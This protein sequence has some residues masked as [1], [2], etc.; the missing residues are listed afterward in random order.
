MATAKG[1][2]AGRQERVSYTRQTLRVS[3]WQTPHLHELLVKLQDSLL[4][5]TSLQL[6]RLDPVPK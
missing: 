3:G 1:L 4:Q 5:L 2:A 6:E